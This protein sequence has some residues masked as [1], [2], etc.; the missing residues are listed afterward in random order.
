MKK[1]ILALMFVS[2][3]SYAT[4]SLTFN[5]F[6][7]EANS[8]ASA[9]SI[10]KS[11]GGSGGSGGYV[12]FES[13]DHKQPVSSAIAPAVSIN[14]ACPVVTVGGHAAQV[15]GFGISTTGIPNINSFCA[16]MMLKQYGIAQQMLCN[17]DSSYRK[18]AKQTGISCAE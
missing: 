11:S 16:A 17:S 6:E 2:A 14:E 9:T 1:I 3:H 4:G 10:S 12:N 8:K 7:A 13:H 15:F 18:A 5:S